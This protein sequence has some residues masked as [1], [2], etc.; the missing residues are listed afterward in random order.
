MERTD[1]MTD[2]AKPTEVRHPSTLLEAVTFFADLDRCND[3][4]YAIK[5]PTGKPACPK[6]GSDHVGR[7]SSRPG[8]LKCNVKKCQKQ[9]SLKKDTLFEDSPLSLQIWFVAL[10]ALVNA[11][12]GISSYELARATGITQKSAWFVLHRLR[13]A[14]KA[15]H[16][17][18]LSGTVESDET[19]IGGKEKNK[20][21]S[22]R[23][24]RGRGTVGKLIVQGLLERGGEL[25]TQVRPNQKRQ[26]LQSPMREQVEPGS[27][28]FTDSLKSYE[29]LD[30]EYIHKM[31]DHAKAYVEGEVHTNSLENAWSLFKRCVH[32]TWVQLGDQ[33]LFRYLDEQTWRF[34]RRKQDDEG[35]FKWAVAAVVGKRLTWKEL[36]G[37]VADANE[38]R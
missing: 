2:T 33:H 27:K 34:N 25:R 10:W 12:N 38:S 32:G 16:V 26:T 6:C 30:D 3:Y 11:K 37:P 14:L 23:Q 17:G 31:I 28:V 4:L 20:H 1:T 5:Y 35:R 8:I 29:G 13:L 21:A 9:F 22:K 36:I 18:K 24:H 15:K 7:I 19:F